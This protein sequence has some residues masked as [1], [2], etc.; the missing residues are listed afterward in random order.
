MIPGEPGIILWGGREPRWAYVSR[1]WLS[2]LGALE[3]PW[4]AASRVPGEP[5]GGILRL[6]VPRAQNR[7]GWLRPEGDESSDSESQNGETLPH[8]FVLLNERVVR[9]VE[10]A[11]LADI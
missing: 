9:R 5:G 4:T 11:S 3:S 8:R 7:Q 6:P 1:P 2:R 10:S